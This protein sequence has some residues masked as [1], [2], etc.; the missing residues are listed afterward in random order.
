MKKGKEV[1]HK[2]KK[3]RCKNGNYTAERKAG[4]EAG[5]KAGEEAGRKAG[6]EG[7]KKAGRKEIN[8]NL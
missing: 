3:E 5:R 2:G 8:R 4:E 6:K 1:R 7:R